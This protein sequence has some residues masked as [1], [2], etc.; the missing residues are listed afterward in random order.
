MVRSETMQ[1][2]A[3]MRIRILYAKF[4]CNR[5]TT[6]KDIKDWKAGDFWNMK[7]Y[8]TSE[9]NCIGGI[10]TPQFHKVH[11]ITE[12]QRWMTS[13]YNTWASHHCA[14]PICKKNNTLLVSYI[15]FY[16]VTPLFIITSVKYRQ[17]FKI[18]S[19]L[20]SQ[21]NFL[22]KYY[23]ASYLTLDVSLHYLVNVKII[24]AANFCGIL[25]CETSEFILLNGIALNP[26]NQKVLT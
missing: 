9:Y 10:S 21:V 17:I 26:N 11:S 20:D 15:S 19:L 8:N 6:V 1:A 22:H 7:Q 18:P 4:H 16:F 5:F 25:S 12:A 3:A 14:E 13:E 24:I 2:I 23:Q